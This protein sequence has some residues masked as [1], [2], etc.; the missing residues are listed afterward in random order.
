[1]VID[2]QFRER[3]LRLIV[4]GGFVVEIERHRICIG[5]LLQLANMQTLGRTRNR[6]EFFRVDAILGRNELV[7]QRCRAVWQGQR[8]HHELRRFH[9]IGRKDFRLV[10]A[11]HRIVM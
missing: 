3:I 11:E 8:D 2:V 10:H 7:G 9:W 5:G 1:M 4:R 6:R